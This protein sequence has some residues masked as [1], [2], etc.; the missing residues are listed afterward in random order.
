[1]QPTE[2][3][4]PPP[5]A[6]ALSRPLQTSTDAPLPLDFGPWLKMSP[7]GRDFVGR[8]LRREWGVR[9]TAADAL[10]HPWW[11]PGRALAG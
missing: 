6:R 2:R 9:M 5:R 8:C 10:Q 7:E 1:M 11:A 4:P 3:H